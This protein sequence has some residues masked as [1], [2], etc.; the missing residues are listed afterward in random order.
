MAHLGSA[1]ASLNNSQHAVV[2]LDNIQWS[3]P[4]NIQ[5]TTHSGLPYSDLP[6]VVFPAVVYPAV[7]YPAVV[8]SGNSNR[9]N[10]DICNHSGIIDPPS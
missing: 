10:M 1:V 8:N 5:Q 4:V 7:I 9:D 6:A 2:S 3:T